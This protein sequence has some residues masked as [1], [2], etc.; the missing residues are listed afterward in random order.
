MSTRLATALFVNALMRSA[1][2]AGGHIMVLARG[3]E[4]AGGLILLCCEK[5]TLCAVYERSF[6]VDNNMVWHQNIDQAIDNKEK[7]RNYLARRRDQDM[8]LWLVEL[9]IPQAERFAADFIAHP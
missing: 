6:D 2:A 7:I 5:G 8:D 4:I 3:D 1:N 9:D